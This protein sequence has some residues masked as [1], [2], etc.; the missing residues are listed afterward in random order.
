[1]QPSR[2][3]SAEA[4][5]PHAPSAEGRRQARREART[6]RD[7]GAGI[8][9]RSS[10]AGRNDTDTSN[11][12]HDH[13]RS[14]SAARSRAGRDVYKRQDW[15]YA[16][17]P[18]VFVRVAYD[19]KTKTVYVFDEDRGLRLS[20]EQTASRIKARLSDEDRDGSPTYLPRAPR[21]RVYADAAEPK[22]VASY[23]AQDIDC[24]AAA[25]WPGSVEELSLIHILEGDV[26]RAAQEAQR[27][28][29]ETDP[30]EGLVLAYLDTP[31]PVGFEGYTAEERDEFWSL[32]ADFGAGGDGAEAAA[33]PRE[34]VSVME[35]WH[36]CL[37]Q[38]ATKP[39]RCV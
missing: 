36:E 24:R 5:H 27:H 28:A 37:R 4:Q 19:R 12:S 35:I 9:S 39:T 21:N 29:M 31:V 14:G 11:G 15:G 34:A 16:V 25:K 10:D 20:N 3:P 18:W 33:E 8:G 17:D 7:E 30:R 2:A 22:S 23:R 32:R 1:M 26:E 6:K 13:G 38:P